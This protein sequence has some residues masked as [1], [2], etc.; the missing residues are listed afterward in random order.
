MQPSFDQRPHTPLYSAFL[1]YYN[2]LIGTRSYSVVEGHVSSIYAQAIADL[3]DDAMPD[4]DIFSLRELHL[5]ELRESNNSILTTSGTGS[6]NT[7]LAGRRN[8]R[9]GPHFEWWKS[10]IWRRRYLPLGER[11]IFRLIVDFEKT[12]LPRLVPSMSTLHKDTILSGRLTENHAAEIVT[13]LRAGSISNDSHATLVAEP[14][15]F[16]FLSTSSHFITF[17]QLAELQ[18]NIV[19][20]LWEPF[21]DHSAFGTHVSDVMMDWSTGVN[22]YTC[23]AGF[24]HSMPLTANGQNLLN[25]NSLPEGWSGP[26]DLFAPLGIIP[27]TCGKSRLDFNF[28]AHAEC[29]IS[30]ERGH[31]LALA[32]KLV[33]PLQSIQ[34]HQ[35][36][37]TITIFYYSPE[38]TLRQD[39][40]DML[41]AYWSHYGFTLAWRPQEFFQT[42]GYKRPTFFRYRES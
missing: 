27:C 4:I 15:H 28:H 33:T 29:N 31:S 39:D 6:L 41:D 5:N 2:S 23:S 17:C 7:G 32:T 13:I 26:S 10:V 40:I 11:R 20:H 19:S 1:D 36:G 34:F 22:F 25:L 9:F 14:D 24:Y 18:F 16:L 30:R 21:F 37:D 38:E 3:L 8:Y 35:N 42:P 12:D